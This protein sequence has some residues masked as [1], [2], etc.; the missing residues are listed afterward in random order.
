MILPLPTQLQQQLK[1]SEGLISAQRAEAYLR[2]YTPYQLGLFVEPI[3]WLSQFQAIPS[4]KRTKLP[5]R[6]IIDQSTIVIQITTATVIIDPH[7]QFDP[8]RYTPDL[9][10]VT[11]A[12]NDHSGGLI[13]LCSVYPSCAVV[14]S[15]TTWQLCAMHESHVITPIQDAVG[16]TLTEDGRAQIIH[17]IEVRGYPAGH[18]IGACMVDIR[19]NNI[20]ILISG[21][22]CIR[23]T[24]HAVQAYWPQHNY[25]LVLLEGTHLHDRQFPVADQTH[26]NHAIV[27]TCVQ[28][29]AEHIVITATALGTAQDIYTHL[30]S[31]QMQGHLQRYQIMLHGKAAAVARHYQH[32]YASI[33]SRWKLPIHELTTTIPLRP[34]IVITSATN[35]H[36]LATLSQGGMLIREGV[37]QLLIAKGSHYYHTSHAS[38]RE[39]ICTALAIPCTHVGFYHSN[40]SA[41]SFRP[42]ADLLRACGRSA[43]LLNNQE[44]EA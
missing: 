27:S 25:D 1:P 34:S 15:E 13:K 23:Q 2:D 36:H 26:N 43:H 28:S 8:Y 10:I 21:D 22:F 40:T 12:H 24:A 30:L 38:L 31:V 16:Y 37:D 11:H 7:D 35:E 17:G 18:L 4:D 44:W 20:Y 5:Y 6:V 3:E 42:V 41:H 19:V 29:H 9:I 32:Q 39:L 33:Q 14:M